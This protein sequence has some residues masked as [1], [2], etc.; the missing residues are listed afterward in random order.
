MEIKLDITLLIVYDISS[1]LRKGFEPTL[2]KGEKRMSEIQ[3]AM[4]L[5]KF[6][7]NSKDWGR[8]DIPEDFL[9]EVKSASE[10]GIPAALGYHESVGWF[11]LH[12]GQGPYIAK[13]QKEKRK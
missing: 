6:I 8:M 13:C 3:E 7:I 11:I 12:S 9:E 5:E 2:R 10:A 1:S 4:F